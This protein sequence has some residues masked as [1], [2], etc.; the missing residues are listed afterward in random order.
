M[1]GFFFFSLRLL[2][3]FG[4][5][6]LFF[7]NIFFLNIFSSH[8]S[9]RHFLYC[10]LCWFLVLTSASVS[11]SSSFRPPVC[12]KRLR[13]RRGGR[14]A[15][16]WSPP[17]PAWWRDCWTTGRN[18]SSDLCFF[19]FYCDIFSRLLLLHL[20]DCMKLGEVDGKKIGCTVS[21]LVSSSYYSVCVCLLSSV[22]V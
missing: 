3:F 5:F 21:L 15:S 10:T 7:F 8:I 19:Y 22:Q 17:S 11:V 1:T 14:A 16:L 4:A 13:G 6:L 12:W 20:R 18:T 2:L 9:F